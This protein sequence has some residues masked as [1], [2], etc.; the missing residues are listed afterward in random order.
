M[1]SLR[2]AAAVSSTDLNNVTS[3]DVTS[4]DVGGASTQPSFQT[5][6]ESFH[7]KRKAHGWLFF[8]SEQNWIQALLICL[9]GLCT[10]DSF[11]HPLT[12]ILEPGEVGCQEV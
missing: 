2:K 1:R 12:S 6:V 3:I 10:P 7:S 5:Y 4:I 9:L 11:S 8:T